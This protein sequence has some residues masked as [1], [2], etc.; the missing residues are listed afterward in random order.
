MFDW[1][2]ILAD[3]VMR[4][5]AGLAFVLTGIYYVLIFAGLL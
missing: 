1:I 3:G 4:V 2:Q 5:L